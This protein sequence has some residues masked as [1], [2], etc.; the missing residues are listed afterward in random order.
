MPQ[1]TSKSFHSLSAEHAGFAKHPRFWTAHHLAVVNCSFQQVESEDK[2][3]YVIPDTEQAQRMTKLASMLARGV[4]REAKSSGWVAELLLHNRPTPITLI[5]APFLFD[6][7]G[8][9]VRLGNSKVTIYGIKHDISIPHADPI[10]GYYGYSADKERK[11]MLYVPPGPNGLDND[12]I[13]GIC[14]IRYRQVTPPDWRRDP[15]FV[16]LLIDLAQL[17]VR[18]GLAPQEGTFLARLLVT[19]V[20]DLTNAYVYKADIPHQL[21]D[22][23]DHPTR[24]IDDFVF[25]KVN[26]VVVPFEPYLTFADRVRFQ[27]A[28]AEYSSSPGPVRSDQ[29]V[30]S[31]PHGEKRKRDED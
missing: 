29:V 6:Y 19:N 28:G 17:Q 1:T 24:S 22:S 27:L 14:D 2:Q 21:L 30:A 9:R 7:G 18:E 20:T 25:P 31:E 12:P 3:E 26:Y 16:C 15:Y 10:I 23:L 5:Y 13:Q 4:R 11:N 8:H